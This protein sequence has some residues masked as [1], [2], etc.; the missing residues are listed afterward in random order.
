M[1]GL[2]NAAAFGGAADEVVSLGK[3]RDQRLFNE[4]V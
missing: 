2:Q 4:Q 3:C 1:A